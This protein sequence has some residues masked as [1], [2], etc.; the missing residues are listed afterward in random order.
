M[1]NP[2][3][4]GGRLLDLVLEPVDDQEVGLDV[5]RPRPVGGD[6]LRSRGDRSQA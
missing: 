5:D 3:T 2:L 1:A 4:T 6:V